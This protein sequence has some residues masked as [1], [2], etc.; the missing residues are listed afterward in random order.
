MAVV[1][2]FLKIDGLPGETQDAEHKGEHDLR[3]FSFLVENPKPVGG[4]G[5][6]KVRF[7]DLSI[8]KTTD[9]ASPI[10]F[11]NCVGGAHYK[12]AV[13]T[14]RKAGGD[15][16]GAGQP[17]LTFKFNTV[18]TTKID[19]SGPGDE[20]PE[21][22]ISFAYGQLKAS[23]G[24]TEH[25]T[26]LPAATGNLVY[27]PAT[28]KF[29]VVQ[30]PN[31]IL[32]VGRT[33]GV[34]GRGVQE[35]DIA[36]LIGLLTNPFGT[37]N[38]HLRINEIRQAAIN[39]GITAAASVNGGTT[40]APQPS[41]Y[42]VILYTPADGTLTVEDL[43]RPGTRLGTITVDPSAPPTSLDL[44]VTPIVTRRNLSQFGIRI[45]LRGASLPDLN[46]DKGDHSDNEGDGN[47]NEGALPDV[48]SNTFSDEQGN[49]EGDDKKRTPPPDVSASFTADLVFN[50]Q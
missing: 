2:Y 50:S 8:T 46:D 23:F 18:F 32:T 47:N 41:T 28:K 3:T 43:T 26:Y 20:G 45:Q 17:F 35:Y 5:A 11:K 36:V 30:T 1:D 14:A 42:D 16:K 10:F 24:P 4:A 6:G 39:P 37:A 38:L 9:K 12:E 34:V 31:G 21:E 29:T 27:D 7:H 48:G 44:D 19:W 40:S 25:I 22:S 13:L 15:G 49:F 33:G